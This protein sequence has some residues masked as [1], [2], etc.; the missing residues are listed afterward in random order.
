MHISSAPAPMDK[1][2]CVECRRSASYRAD[3]Q[4]AR[5]DRGFADE[6]P[7]H[8]TPPTTLDCLAPAPTGASTVKF[9]PGGAC[10][11]DL[12]DRSFS[13]PCLAPL[14]SR[15]PRDAPEQA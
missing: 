12:S 2:L 5:H 6:Q 15:A 11:F 1:T 3:G 7:A 14:A 4:R 10:P 13:V 9:L 8:R